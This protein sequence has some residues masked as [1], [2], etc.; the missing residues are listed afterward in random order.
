MLPNVKQIPLSELP[1]QSRIGPT[2]VSRALY[3]CII[4]EVFSIILP[5]QQNLLINFYEIH[6]FLFHL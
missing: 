6:S 4:L 5:A 3:N 2:D 1:K